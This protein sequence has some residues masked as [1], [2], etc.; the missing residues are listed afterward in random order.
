MR[1]QSGFSPSLFSDFYSL[2]HPARALQACVVIPARDEACRIVA[3]LDALADQRAL[4]GDFLPRA[5][6]ETLIL[7][8]NCRDETANVARAWQK[9]HPDFVLH[10][11]EA[12]F[13]SSQACVGHARRILM[14]A[15]H[16]RTQFWPASKGEPRA[17]CSTD[18]DTRVSPFWVA[19]ILENL[20]AGAAA[21]GGRVYLERDCAGS[22]ARRIYLF[23][24]A[25]RLAKA[26]LQDKIAGQKRETPRHFQFFGATLA[27]RPTIYARLG[28]LPIVR[29]LE[30]VALERE[31]LRHDLPIHYAPQVAVWTCARREGRVETGLSTQL[32][33][34]SALAE[35]SVWLVPSGAEIEFQAQ[36]KRR[37]RALF[38]QKNENETEVENLARALK[39]DSQN[40][41]NR[42]QNAEFFGALWDDIWTL[43]W[44]NAAFRADWPPVRVEKALE[45]LRAL[46]ARF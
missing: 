19:H 40:L 22:P 11:V 34:W 14:D 37:L 5:H 42:L 32:D 12:D 13:D 27:I 3:A 4:N 31:L 1:S 45:Q 17:I 36:L 35:D 18:A 33:Q 16:L 44:D 8:N 7:A 46:N 6:F 2:P 9:L 41:K 10:L 15:A 25:Y 29:A 28:G 24:T 21:V 43:A 39:I 30:D 26:R 38:D 20:R 23:D